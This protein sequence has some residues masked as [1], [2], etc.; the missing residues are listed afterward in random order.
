MLCMM[1]LEVLV[2]LRLDIGWFCVL[3]V[4]FKSLVRARALK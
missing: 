3:F 1:H 4:L 2:L